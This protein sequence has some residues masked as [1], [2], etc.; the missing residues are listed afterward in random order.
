MLISDSVPNFGD[1][2]YAILQGDLHVQGGN[3]PVLIVQNNVGNKFSP[4]VEILPL[5]SNIQKAKNMPTHVLVSASSEN[6]LNRDS[7][8]FGEQVRTINKSQLIDKIG[9]LEHDYLVCVGKAR[10]IQSPF[11]NA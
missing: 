9:S 11:P 1:I 3:R 7:V 2:F 8:V 4:T 5:S 10:R 6:G